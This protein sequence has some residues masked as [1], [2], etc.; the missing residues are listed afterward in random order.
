M[1]DEGPVLTLLPTTI[2]FGILNMAFRFEKDSAE[3]AIRQNTGQMTRDTGKTEIRG[4]PARSEGSP[5]TTYN[6]RSITRR[7]KGRR[8][9]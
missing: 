3:N 7:S 5:A 2:P 1:N 9:M 8:G 6:Y 4:L